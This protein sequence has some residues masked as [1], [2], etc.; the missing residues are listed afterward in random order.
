MFYGFYARMAPL[1]FDDRLRES[2]IKSPLLSL[3][4]K[5]PKGVV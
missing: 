3:F 2:A 1:I 4:L 5:D